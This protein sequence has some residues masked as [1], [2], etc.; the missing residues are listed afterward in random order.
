[1]LPASRK[2][3]KITKNPAVEKS[4]C[5]GIFCGHMVAIFWQKSGSK[6]AG[7]FLCVKSGF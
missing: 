7:K 1:V 3:C 6:L 5:R 4:T 2:F